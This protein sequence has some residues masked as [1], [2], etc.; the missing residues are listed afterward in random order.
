MRIASEPYIAWFTLLPDELQRDIAVHIVHMW[1]SHPLEERIGDS[2]LPGRLMDWVVNHSS[3]RFKA[4]GITLGVMRITE[5][6]FISQRGTNEDWDISLNWLAQESDRLKLAGDTFLSSSLER[7]QLSVPAPAGAWVNAAEAWN[8]IR[9]SVL[10]D[11]ALHFC[12][13]PP[14]A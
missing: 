2:D 3:E 10:S 1:P 11:D 5:F 8:K 13:R 12:L 6:M 4:V 7:M 9:N 14:A